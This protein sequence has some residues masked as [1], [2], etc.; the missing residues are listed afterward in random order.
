M[1]IQNNSVISGKTAKKA[2]RSSTDGVFGQLLDSSSRQE[3]GERGPSDQ[4][5]NPS[6]N[7]PAHPLP[8]ALSNPSQPGVNDVSSAPV[9]E[10]WHTLGESVTLLDEAMH[11][12]EAGNSPP[13]QLIADI[14]Q[15]RRSLRQQVA[16]GSAAL[17]LRQADTLLAVEAER[18]RS[19]QS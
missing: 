11:C 19:M 8:N 10:A 2:T 7:K 6:F 5:S 17:E 15:L 18:I 9:Q 3:Q 1:K 13:H 12:L 16:S 4:S 14:E